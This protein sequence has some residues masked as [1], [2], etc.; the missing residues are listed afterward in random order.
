MCAMFQ[1]SKMKRVLEIDCQT[2]GIVL[3]ATEMYTKKWQ[4][5]NIY[6]LCLATVKKYTHRNKKDT[7]NN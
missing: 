5:G 1:L 6:V 7:H 4:D 2:M 3:K